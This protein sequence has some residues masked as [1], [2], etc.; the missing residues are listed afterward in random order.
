LGKSEFLYSPYL[1]Q[2]SIKHGI[3]VE[4]Q[5]DVIKLLS[6]RLNVVGTFNASPSRVQIRK[7]SKLFNSVTILYDDDVAG[8][9]GASQLGVEL[10]D[11][12]IYSYRMKTVRA[13][14]AGAYSCINDFMEDF[15][16]RKFLM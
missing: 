2:P 14:D 16:D 6:F 3:I 12:G 4:G 11:L 13:E 10:N 7:I 1:P 5:F 15:K 9:M 8:N